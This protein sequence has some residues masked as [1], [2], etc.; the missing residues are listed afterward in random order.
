MFNS[1]GQL[2]SFKRGVIWVDFMSSFRLR[3]GDKGGGVT[4][5]GQAR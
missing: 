2:V 5:G 3:V 4:V 1:Q